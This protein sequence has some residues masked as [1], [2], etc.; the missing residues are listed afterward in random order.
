MT[1]SNQIRILKA[2]DVARHAVVTLP[3]PEAPAAPRL[4]PAPR[5][6]AGSDESEVDVLVERA[7][8][9]GAADAARLLEPSLRQLAGALSGLAEESAAARYAALRADSDAIVDTALL[10][11]RWILDRELSEP[12]AV[13]DLAQRAL[14]E[15]GQSVATRLRVHPDLAAVL[16]AIAPDDLAVVADAS[17]ARGEFV[18]ETAGPDVAFRFEQ[19]IERAREAL[20]EEGGAA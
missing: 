19:A 10:V 3:R 14:A 6:A 12:D 5:I 16:E 11:C 15:T 20:R 4:D 13:L 18:T 8:A 2:D 1:M 17:L 7:R 9:E